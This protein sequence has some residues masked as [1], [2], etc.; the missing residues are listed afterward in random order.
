MSPPTHTHIPTQ[1]RTLFLPIKLLLLGS[2]LLLTLTAL[3]TAAAAAAEDDDE[4]DYIEG[5]IV[6][7]GEE[8][9]E[10]AQAQ[11]EIN[12]QGVQAALSDA[13]EEV[14]RRKAQGEAKVERVIKTAK[15]EAG[16]PLDS[17]V[18]RLEQLERQV[19]HDGP[20]SG[21]VVGDELGFSLEAL[22]DDSKS[23][24][25]MYVGLCRKCG[26]MVLFRLIGFLYIHILTHS[27][28]P[29]HF[30]KTK[31]CLPIRLR[32]HHHPPHPQNRP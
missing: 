9:L 22:E 21:G 1:R 20:G 30:T 29:T 28:P 15:R 26:C 25:E 11:V 2:L 16:L 19:Q 27:H 3:P 10:Q 32:L 17:I 5:T 8:L 14:Q 13:A 31:Q 18:E 7:E 24:L 23:M 6:E 12:A 4:N